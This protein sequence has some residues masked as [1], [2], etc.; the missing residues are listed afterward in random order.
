MNAQSDGLTVSQLCERLT[1]TRAK[2]KK[3]YMNCGTKLFEVTHIH[4][5]DRVVI[6]SPVVVPKEAV[7]A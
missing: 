4:E 3:V 7:P 2:E 5:T 6:L 1:Q